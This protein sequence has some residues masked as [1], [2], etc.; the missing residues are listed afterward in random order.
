M[1]D[2]W[3]MRNIT[4]ITDQLT[5]AALA[6]VLPSEGVAEVI[7]TED[8]A[9]RRGYAVDAAPG[10]PAFRMANRFT[11]NYRI[12][13]VV[14]EDA[15]DTVFDAV[16]FAYGAGFFGDAEAWVNATAAKAA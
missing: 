10:A 2:S 12:D 13:L 15:V 9:L 1:N 7:V 8:R 5:D 6:A 14:E 16:S 4:I 3:G 11:A